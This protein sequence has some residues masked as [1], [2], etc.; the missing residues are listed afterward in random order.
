MNNKVYGYVTERIL[1]S[2]DE[3]TVPWRKPWTLPETPRNIITKKP[4]R[5][6]NSILLNLSSFPSPYWLT[7][8]QATSLGCNIKRGEKPTMVVFYK[9]LE[10]K[11][12]N[13]EKV[14]KIPYL[15]YYNVFNAS[16]CEGI[17]KH[18]PEISNK[19]FE[20]IEEAARIIREMP[21]RPN[22]VEGN[23]SSYVNS[24][25]TIYLPPA[26]T[27]NSPE[28]YYSVAFHELV[29]S[30][31]HESRLKRYSKMEP[32]WVFNSESYS[33][34]ELIAEMGAAFLCATIG[35]ENKTIQ[36]SASYID[37]WRR[38]ISNDIKLVVRAANQAQKAVD[39]ILNIKPETETLVV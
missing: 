26:V 35:I 7:Y 31:G 25:D 14:E 23:R 33:K 21:L 38:Q 10:Y 39:Y 27:F 20:P 6:I 36:N 15:R 29:H 12:D 13:Q 30:T 8:R 22:I 4:Y 37:G 5:G 1:K 18:I 19:V 28:E 17:E 32:N 9:T 2:L 34:E 3:G 24:T 16:Q 11:K